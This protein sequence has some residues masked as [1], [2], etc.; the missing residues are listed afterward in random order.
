[1]SKP[2]DATLNSMI[3]LRPGEWA[4]HF[5]RLA[6]IPP[7][8]SV[9]LD[10]DLATTLTADKVFRI[11]GERPSLL[12]L[13]LQS[14]SRL[15]IPAE[16]MRYN[17]LISHQ[18]GLLPVETVLILLRPKALA[19]DQTGVYQ[20][21][22]V[23]GNL[24]AE[25]RYHVVRVWEHPSQ[26]WLDGGVSLAPLSLLTDEADADLD[27]ALVRLQE[28]LR[29]HRVDE[30]AVK[31]LLGSSYVLCGLRYER[32]RVAEMYRRLS[33]LLEESTTYQEILGKGLSQ[34]LSQ[35]RTQGVREGQ[36]NLLMLQ[37]TKRFGQPDETI[38]RA[39]HAIE[40]PARLARL[41]ERILEAAD[42]DDLLR[43]E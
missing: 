18:H 11:N 27:R 14:G 25:F 23:S 39:L 9:P 8:P 5:A 34:G 13:E 6:G 19:G 17:T 41:G 26:Y 37:G 43:G 15:G 20:R 40:D 12:H 22:G 31:S 36:H 38:I 42:W 7:G 35:G 4:A 24:I 1:M 32:E 33:M 30:T 28:C 21:F 10:T 2:F 3:D 16:L 29:D